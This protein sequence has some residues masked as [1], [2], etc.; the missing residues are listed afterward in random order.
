MYIYHLVPLIHSSATI[1]NK[2]KPT[3]SSG[4]FK[5][6]KLND[7]DITNGTTS[8]HN[9]HN[10]APS[11]PAQ[12]P[13]ALMYGIDAYSTIMS[14]NVL[15]VG[16][17]GIGC[18]LLK[19]LLLSGFQSISVIDLDTIDV[20]NLNRQ[21][22]FR[23][24]NVGQSKSTSAVL[25][26]Q[27][28]NPQCKLT[29]YHDNIK[30][31]QYN[32][33][34]YQQFNIVLNALDNIDARRHVNRLCVNNNIP[35]IESGTQGY[36]GNVHVILPQISECYECSPK[37][38]P[39]QFA[40]C[41]IRHTPDKPIHCVV[42]AKMVFAALF[43]PI[44]TDN[45]LHDI[46]SIN[47]A[48]HE[49]SQQYAKTVFDE[50]FDNEIQKQ[51]EV[52]DRWVNRSPPTPLKLDTL[53][54]D[55]TPLNDIQFNNTMTTAQSAKL[56]IDCIE[57]LHTQ[58]LVG[59]AEFDKDNVLYMNTVAALANLRMSNFAIPLQSQFILKGIAGNIVHAIA[60]TNAITAGQIVIEAINVL[61]EHTDKCR[62]SWIKRT[63]PSLL[64]PQAMDPP[65]KQCYI[66]NTDN[67][68][69]LRVNTN[70]FT[71]GQLYQ[72]V[73]IQS[74]S[75]NEPS[76]D[77]TNYDNYIGLAEDH[78]HDE[79][80]TNRSLADVKCHDSAELSIDDFA[81]K[82]TLKIIIRH[83]DT[84]NPDDTPDMFIITNKSGQAADVQPDNTDTAILP[85]AESQQVHDINNGAV[86]H[87]KHSSTADI[88]DI[89]EIDQPDNENTKSHKRSLSDTQCESDIKK[90]KLVQVN[91]VD[92]DIIELD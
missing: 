55:N 62:V 35:L 23:R 28:I 11:T 81:Q 85:G 16:A 30:H 47:H 57:Q 70:T 37:P 86:A 45:A 40:V 79:T 49:S 24:H 39:K 66:C 7:T 92:D 67:T 43:G 44:D 29:A 9:D 64:T 19:C 54:A 17:G 41:T 68:L 71:I 65:N 91:P 51:V 10:A 26:V 63:V 50:L 59:T 77:V 42:W 72:R 60:T 87:V 33:E 13:C 3:K 74:L 18:E 36:T 58:K 89:I 15:V 31:Q 82:F 20:S 34:W 32:T 80:F 61:T 53:L 21:F 22:L 5:K 27:H 38:T 90:A 73:L 4:A 46:A 8:N 6:A 25:A 48:Q 14:S 56:L 1:M 75:M 69:I 88:N 76:I 83:D 78:E 2:R 84:I 12:H 52:K